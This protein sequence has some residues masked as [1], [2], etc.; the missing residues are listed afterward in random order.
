[1]NI[2]AATTDLNCDDNEIKLAQTTIGLFTLECDKWA[3]KKREAV[4]E[5]FIKF[6][7]GAVHTL[8]WPK[9]RQ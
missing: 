2:D 5:S 8:D 7:Y 9:N 1:M 6:I 3:P 4:I